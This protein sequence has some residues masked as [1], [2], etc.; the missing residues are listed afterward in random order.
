MNFLAGEEENETRDERQMFN[1]RA[2]RMVD[3]ARNMVK[4]IRDGYQTDSQN[5]YN[6]DCSALVY[7]LDE[8]KDAL[9]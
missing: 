1:A 4:G 9:R 2:V 6:S 7:L 8:I 3:Q 5:E